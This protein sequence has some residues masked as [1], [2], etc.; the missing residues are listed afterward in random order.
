MLPRD[1]HT[2]TPAPPLA[3][4]QEAFENEKRLLEAVRAGNETETRRLLDSWTRPLEQ[5]PNGGAERFLVLGYEILP[6]RAES[7]VQVIPRLAEHIG[8]ASIGERGE[9]PDVWELDYG[10]H[11]LLRA[12]TPPRALAERW[13]RSPAFSVIR[14]TLDKPLAAL[15]DTICRDAA[16]LR[17][18]TGHALPDGVRAHP[19][20][21]DD[22]DRATG[23]KQLHTPF[24]WQETDV[25]SVSEAFHAIAVPETPWQRG[26]ALLNL[27]EQSLVEPIYEQDGVALDLRQKL[28]E[29]MA[30]AFAVTHGGPRSNLDD[31]SAYWLHWHTR[32][33]LALAQAARVI[34]NLSPEDAW[35]TATWL[36]H[37][38]LKSP[39]LPGDEELVAIQAQAAIPDETPKPNDLLDPFCFSARGDGVH[40]DEVSL[41]LAI[42]QHIQRA[43][44][45]KRGPY[46]FPGAVLQAIRRV[47]NR[48][49]NS[50]EKK[51]LELWQSMSPDAR[52]GYRHTPPAPPFLARRILHDLDAHWLAGLPPEAF[53]ETLHFLE[54]GLR[55]EDRAGWILVALY[56]E[57]QA[58][59]DHARRLAAQTWL[60]LVSSP[61][62]AKNVHRLA[63]AG[64]GLF[65]ALD[66]AGI[67]ALDDLV[68]NADPRWKPGLYS[69]LARA[70]QRTKDPRR[71]EVALKALAD[72]ALDRDADDQ[73]RLDAAIL[74]ARLFHRPWHPI[75]DPVRRALVRASTQPPLDGNTALRRELMRVGVI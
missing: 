52:N 5:N 49:L 63:L 4:A 62:I 43:R 65:P 12:E 51:I 24:P 57:D 53:E 15:L 19:G 22:R 36:K 38:L 47:G 29:T 25:F 61:P 11:R 1:E 60:K 20:K 17:E 33:H 40:P 54:T 2:S 8:R 3:V 35:A 42:A 59:D 14:F 45:R 64:I 16:V 50:G 7:S 32:A 48:T 70:A 56:R 67:R 68:E 44:D 74:L 41:L 66:A 75:P 55:E 34:G 72:L 37:L 6:A 69:G 10:L 18:T 9:P 31:P 27:L 26:L 13:L 28:G 23:W 30:T 39:F 21:D 46:A 58:L 71:W 73:Q